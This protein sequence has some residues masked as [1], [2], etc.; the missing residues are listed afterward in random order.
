MAY[1]VEIL[2][3]VEDQEQMEK[4]RKLNKEA[5]KKI[6]PKSIQIEAALY[7]G[8]ERISHFSYSSPRPFSQNIEFE[9]EEMHFYQIADSSQSDEP[10]LKLS[11]LPSNTRLVL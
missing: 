9:D 6:S 10:R 3:K 11:N 2:H 7:L 1:R 4:Y 8:C 5:T